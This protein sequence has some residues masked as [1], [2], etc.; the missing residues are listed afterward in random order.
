MHIKAAK[1]ALIFSQKISIVFCIN[2]D[3]KISAPNLL[4]LSFIGL[5][6]RISIMNCVVCALNCELYS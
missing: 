4:I 1:Y 3:Y 2:C 5:A 6:E